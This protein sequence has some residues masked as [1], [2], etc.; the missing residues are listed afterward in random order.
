MSKIT[1]LVNAGDAE[2]QV[3]LS[4]ILTH[5]HFVMEMTVRYTSQDQQ[6]CSGN[7][8]ICQKAV[9]DAH[10]KS[11]CFG[12]IFLFI[13]FF[14]LKLFLTYISLQKHIATSLGV[15]VWFQNELIQRENLGSVVSPV[16]AFS[17]NLLL[18]K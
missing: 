17:R 13:S 6:N 14:V 10:L 4:F 1:Q 15:H 11:M 18:K 12:L 16:W 2:V 8:Y 3:E 5:L 7:I 9:L